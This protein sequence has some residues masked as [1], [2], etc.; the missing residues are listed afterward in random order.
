M[1]VCVCV[2]SYIYILIKYVLTEV[3][4]RNICVIIMKTYCLETATLTLR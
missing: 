4:Y 3:C 2:Y 1:S